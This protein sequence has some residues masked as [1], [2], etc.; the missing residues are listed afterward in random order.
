VTSEQATRLEWFWVAI[1]QRV[2][3][4][5][6]FIA[7]FR[8]IFHQY[9]HPAPDHHPPYISAAHRVLSPGRR[10]RSKH[11]AFL[12]RPGPAPAIPVTCIERDPGIGYFTMN[13]YNFGVPNLHEQFQQ[14][15]F[16]LILEIPVNFER[17]R[18]CAKSSPALIPSV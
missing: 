16:D 6:V 2:V 3:P 13:D 5:S 18:D 17:D 14:D 4:H 15:H 7:K 1:W 10:L 9:R 12:G 8:Q 11:P